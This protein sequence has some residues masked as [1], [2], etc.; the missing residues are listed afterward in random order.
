MCKSVDK[1]YLFGFA[2]VYLTTPTSLVGGYL[3]DHM[4]IFTA[5]NT[6][7]HILLSFSQH[8]E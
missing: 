4:C 7:N 2:F 5:M 3:E 8:R 6:S 1:L